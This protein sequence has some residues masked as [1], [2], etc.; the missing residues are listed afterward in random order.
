MPIAI[1][2]KHCGHNE[3]YLQTGSVHVGL[4]CNN[5]RR[6]VKWLSKSEYETLACQEQTVKEAKES[7][8]ENIDIKALEKQRDELNSKINEYYKKETEKIIEDNAGYIGKTFIR[9]FKDDII[10]YYKII[11]VDKN[12]HYRMMTLTFTLPIVGFSSWHK[13]FNEDSIMSIES[14]GWFCNNL[15]NDYGIPSRE[16]DLYTEISNDEFEK[17]FN[18]WLIKIKEVIK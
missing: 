12:N 16:I 7:L 8:L 14:I 4:Y 17:A 18:T 9:N 2:C 3:G 5:C 10:G 13:P 15:S 11:D 6:W 1:K